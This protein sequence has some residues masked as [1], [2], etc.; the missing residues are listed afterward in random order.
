MP[1]NDALI[2]QLQAAQEEL[3]RQRGFLDSIIENLP[4]MVFVKDAR[5]LRFVRLNKAGEELLGFSRDELLGKSDRDFFPADQAEAFI[6][7][8]RAVLA[9]G[10]LHDIPEEPI[11]TRF[12]GLRYLHTKKIPVFDGSTAP[13]YLLGISEDITE[14]KR[15]AEELRRY[16]ARFRHMVA[17]VADYAIFMLDPDGRVATWNLGAERIKGWKAEEIIGRHFSTFYPAADVANQK[18]DMELREAARL[19]RWEDEGWRV[20]KDGTLLWANVVITAMRDEAGKLAGFVKVTRDL[21]ERRQSEQRIEDLNR[22]LLAANA[23]LE[24]FSY[25]V[26]H[27]L[28]AP[29]RHL[30]GFSKLLL[31]SEGDK[32]SGEALDSLKRIAAGARNM[33]QLIDDLLNLA[34]IGRQPLAF[35]KVR[36]GDLVRQVIEDLGPEYAGRNVEWRVGPLP[37]LQCD[38]GLMKIVFANL[39]GNAVKYSRPRE[40]AVIEIGRAG[41]DRQGALFV[42]DNGVGFDMRYSGKLFGVF[43]RLH[44]ATEFEGTGVGLATV[45]RIMRRHGGRIWAESEVGAGSTFYFTIG[46]A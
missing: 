33:G 3:R 7:R 8:D 1:D 13:V 24:A 31:E 40:R 27:D 36:L 21:T 23:D 5:D 22:Q 46:G 4:N 43:Q 41:P 29:V 17:N 9:E 20:R 32:L 39:L 2:A 15:A 38:S 6:A 37:E 34:R 14:S 18:P 45:E 30:I 25:S 11:Q 12:R 16:E 28:R 10:R 26:A 42:R 35:S 19:G 44:K